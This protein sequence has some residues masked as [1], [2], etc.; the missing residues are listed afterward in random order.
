MEK[1]IL[2][3]PLGLLFAVLA[4]SFLVPMFVNANNFKPAI[5]RKLQESTGYNISID[6]PVTIRLLPSA[7]LR[8]EKVS[9]D[10][11]MQNGDAPFAR[12]QA[13]DVGVELFPLMGGKIEITKILLKNP[14]LN[15]V[16]SRTGS[17]WRPRDT[18]IPGRRASR[19]QNVPIEA[20][21]APNIV[22]SDLEIVNGSVKYSN[23]KTQQVINLSSLNLNA[24]MSSVS[25]PIKLKAKA[26]WNEKPISVE[27]S[28]DSLDKLY[29]QEAASS[30]L[31][32]KSD[33]MSFTIQGVIQ[34]MQ[35]RGEVEAKSASLGDAMDWLSGAAKKHSL[36]PISLNVKTQANCSQ[37]QCVFDNAAIGVNDALFKGG[38]KVSMPGGKPDVIADLAADNLDIT[39]YLP[40]KTASL[41]LIGNAWADSP[42]WSSDPID[43]SALS[44]FNASVNLKL[45]TFKAN[46]FAMGNSALQLKIA[47]RSLLIDIASEE[48]YEG[49]GSVRVSVGAD[50]RAEY[51]IGADGVEIEPLMKALVD[52]DRFSG[53]ANIRLNTTSSGKSQREIV[54]GL[55]GGGSFNIADGSINGVDIAGMV[56]N[57]KSAFV[58]VDKTQKKTDF[59]E[60]GGSFTIKNGTVSNEDL[61]MKAPLFRVSGKGDIDLPQYTI[62]Y[63]LT[64]QLV[65]TLKGQGGKDKQGLGVPVRITGPLDNPQYAPDLAGMVN[66][67]IKDPQKFKENTKEIRSNVKDLLKQGKGLLKGL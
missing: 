38:L 48:F 40:K 41:G 57:V 9:I 22:L 11:P 2:L 17:N 8:V 47:D 25:S 65:D 32:F 54:S 26:L 60:L 12:M 23:L 30:A 63:L 64:P 14:I 16:E 67:A 51:V 34:R 28:L 46:Q 7:R 62:N 24:S 45:A 42:R 33:T 29:G 44:L 53:K 35:F 27:T 52:S 20:R 6:G 21:A 5:V 4:A 19:P 59:A 13:L 1:K 39:P 3:M 49:K 18:D 36:P 56:R 43:F 66:E 10:S 55:N 37:T 31:S 50:L 58:E 15:M 61:I